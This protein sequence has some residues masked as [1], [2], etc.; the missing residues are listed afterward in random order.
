[1]NANHIAAT[2]PQ[3][4]VRRP[5]PKKAGQPGAPRCGTSGTVG[6]RRSSGGFTLIEIIVA[7]SI[8]ASGFLGAFAMVLQ[9]GRLVSAAEEEALV[10]SGLEQRV[11]QLRALEWEELTDGSGITGKVWTARPEATTGCTVF[12][13][14]ITLSAYDVPTAKTLQATWQASKV[15]GTVGTGP[16]LNTAGAVKAV[17]TLTWTGRRSSRLQTRSLVTVIS[18]GGLSKSDLP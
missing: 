7:I 5:F 18:R 8:V 16:E 17:T 12:L 11:D 6:A 1:M 3:T 9:A 10:S 13:E 15:A 14:T 4:A 2:T